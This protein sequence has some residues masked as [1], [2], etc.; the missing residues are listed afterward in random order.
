MRGWA[1]R[2]AEP[3][4]SMGDDATVGPAET[5][6]SAHALVGTYEYM[7]PEV[8]RGVDVDGRADL[9]A[10]GVMAYRLLTGRSVGP[11]RPSEIDANLAPWDAWILKALEE[12][13]ALRFRTAEEMEQGLYAI[14]SAYAS[15]GDGGSVQDHAVSEDAAAPSRSVPAQDSASMRAKWCVTTAKVQCLTPQGLREEELILATTELGQ[16]FVKVLPGEFLMGSPVSEK[17]RGP[18]EEQHV[19]VVEKAFWLGVTPVTNRMF[20]SF[21]PSHTME[22][23]DDAYPVVGVT[24]NLAKEFCRWLSEQVGF[25]CRL[26]TEVEWEYACRAGS[27]TSRYWGD[28]SDA[29]NARYASGGGMLSSLLVGRRR[30]GSSKGPLCVASFHPNAFGAHDMLGN[31]WEWCE[32]RYI[33]Y[34]TAERVCAPEHVDQRRV[35]RGGSWASIPDFCR[36]AVRVK[37][38]EDYSGGEQGFRV[39]CEGS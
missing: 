20:L 34:R 1:E 38:P 23:G 22:K 9:Y 16:K 3:C 32:D 12:D 2:S 4:M 18:D 14:E 8:K 19:A 21:C 15:S 27:N 33:P 11:R 37:Y 24:W 31:V 25:K 6:A 13:P 36:S 5:E 30:N 7:S 26:P 39:L 29:A 17:G 10:V 35:A 28:Q